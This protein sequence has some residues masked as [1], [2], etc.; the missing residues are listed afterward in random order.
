MRE[1][2]VHYA[3]FPSGLGSFGIIWTE[4]QTNPRV[5]R[6]FLPLSSQSLQAMRT[7]VFPESRPGSNPVI[8]RLGK[9]LQRFLKGDAVTFDLNYLALDELSLFHQR[10]LHAEYQVPRGWVTTYG[11]LAGYLGVPKGARAVGWALAHNPF[12]LVIPCHRT[13]RSSGDI[14]GFGGEF[15]GQGGG[16]QMKRALLLMEGVQCS[17]QG[18][19][20]TSNIYF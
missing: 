19:V 12:P 14:G 9:S 11:R 7:Q 20:H 15:R 13:I 17:P 5:H 6:I 8:Q 4:N 10:V 3:I 18:K 1:R 2:V 16:R